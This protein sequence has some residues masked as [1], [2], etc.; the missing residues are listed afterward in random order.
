MPDGQNSVEFVASDIHGQQW[1]LKVSVRNE[2]KY[3]KP[4]LKGE[5]EGYL[6]QKQLRKGD[7][8]ILTMN[9]EGIYRISAERKHFGFCLVLNLCFA[10]VRAVTSSYIFCEVKIKN[11]FG[12]YMPASGLKRKKVNETKVNTHTLPKH[13]EVIKAYAGETKG[14]E[15]ESNGPSGDNILIEN[16]EDKGGILRPL[17]GQLEMEVM[18]KILSESDTRNRRLE[19]PTGS[20]W[21]FP[22]PDGQNSVEFVASDIHGQ[23]WRLKVSVRNEGKYSKPWLKGEWEGYLLQKQLRKGDRVILTMNDEGIYR[24]SA[25]RKHFGF[26]YSIDEQQ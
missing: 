8:V 6:L 25:E 15:M 1:R 16:R 21:A 9:D 5:W 10:S 3:S 24:I 14:D 23:Q 2:G 12:L 22:M 11:I 20:L 13:V 26:W 17:Q 7:R 4:W 18:N 19:F